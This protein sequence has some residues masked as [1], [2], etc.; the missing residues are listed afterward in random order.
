MKHIRCEC[1]HT[2]VYYLVMNSNQIQ[3]VKSHHRTLYEE[4]VNVCFCFFR[5]NFEKLME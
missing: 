4:E 5:V 1:I 2:G 3:H